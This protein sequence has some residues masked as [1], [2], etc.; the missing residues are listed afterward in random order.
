MVVMLAVALLFSGCK[1]DDDE[2]NN[3]NETNT[4]VLGTAIV[5]GVTSNFTQGHLA[6]AGMYEGTE[7]YNY[8]IVL[9]TLG[10]SYFGGTGVGDALIFSI[11]VSSDVFNGGTFA[12]SDDWTV[13]ENTMIS[14][15]FMKGISTSTDAA[16]RSFRTTGGTLTV[17]KSGNDYSLTYSLTVQEIST[18][19]YM[20]VGDL[21]ALTGSFNGVL[22]Y[23][24][25]SDEE[26]MIEKTH[27]FT[28]K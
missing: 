27:K 15:L 14:G 11:I 4:S 5:G 12:Y 7:L 26:K 6:F 28:I 24:D 16:D 1:K 17:S 21:V 8:N 25:S 9:T 10:F 23:L 13:S 2:N 19:T 20:P 3:S 22:T 18:S